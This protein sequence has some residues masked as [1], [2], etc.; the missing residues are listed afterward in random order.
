[1][2]GRNVSP[3]APRSAAGATFWRQRGKASFASVLERSSDARIRD[4]AARR[5]HVNPNSNSAA[6]GAP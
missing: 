1:M 2:L 4:F 3:A 5:R 6:I